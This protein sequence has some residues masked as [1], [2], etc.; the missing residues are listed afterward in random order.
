MLRNYW[1]T[2]IKNKIKIIFFSV[3]P[4]IHH[5]K[6]LDREINP[7][8]TE[9]IEGSSVLLM[10]RSPTQSALP[11]F[12]LG[13]YCFSC[14]Q[15]SKETFNTVLSGAALSYSDLFGWWG[16]FFAAFRD[17]WLNLADFLTNRKTWIIQ[18]RAAL[19]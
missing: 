15:T 19:V 18:V 5:Y 4:D 14:M 9:T 12:F 6:L 1:I 8:T 17:V 7:V 2:K 13:G 10:N 3:L 11:F 16:G